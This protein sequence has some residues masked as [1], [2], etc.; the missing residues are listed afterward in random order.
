MRYFIYGIVTTLLFVAY[1]GQADVFK[2]T[3]ED[4]GLT[5]Q[6][7]PCPQQKV[8]KVA[9]Q[10]AGQA[11]RDCQYAVRFADS[12]AR[13][14]RAGL[15]SS[16][17]F[18]RYNG[19]DSLSRSSI[20]VINYVYS[21]RTA[22][23]VSA[24]RIAGLAEA[25]C[26]VGSFGEAS[27]DSFPMSFTDEFGGCGDGTVDEAAA[28]GRSAEEVATCK[29]HYRDAIDEIDAEIRRGYSSE[30]GETYRQRLRVLTEKLRA[31]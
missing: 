29:Q 2:C 15:T 28:N 6:Q 16:E 22:G 3:A 12:T 13:F 5:F 7:T 27:C 31:C 21:F 10:E 20:S 8:E 14:M 18:D 4:G 30:L 9:T 17:M 1:D 23:D 25:K 24:E 19:L 11:Q 26:R